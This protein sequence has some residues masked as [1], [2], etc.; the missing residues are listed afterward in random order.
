MA[1]TFRGES[2]A[3]SFTSADLTTAGDGGVQDGDLVVIDCSSDDP[4]TVVFTVTAAGSV[5]TK[6][7][8]SA[9][10]VQHQ[11]GLFYKVAGASEP[12]TYNVTHDGATNEGFAV[13]LTVY[14]PNGATITVDDTAMLDTTTTDSTPTTPSVT[15]IAGVDSVGLIHVSFSNDA[16]FTVSAAP[17]DVT[18]VDELLNGSSTPGFNASLASYYKLA[19]VAGAVTM[20]ITWS[21]TDEANAT[22]LIAHLTAAAGGGIMRRRRELT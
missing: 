15:V 12:S 8:E 7:E 16:N 19:Q 9:T 22:V 20:T 13:R 6:A 2:D 21:G 3:G 18:I 4:S 14:N 11:T 5:W 1:W 10:Q 17:S